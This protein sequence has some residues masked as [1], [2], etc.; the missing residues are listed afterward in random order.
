MFSQPRRINSGYNEC[1]ENL[2]T[3]F[4][5]F[6]AS[7]LAVAARGCVT[8]VNTG[9]LTQ[10]KYFLLKFGLGT[11]PCALYHQPPLC[12]ST[13]EPPQLILTLWGTWLKAAFYYAEHTTNKSSIEE[14]QTKFKYV[15]VDRSLKTIHSNY[16]GFTSSLAESLQ[17]VDEINS[18]LQA[19]GD[20]INESD[21]NNFENILKKYTVFTKLYI[22][23]IETY[24]MLQSFYESSPVRD[25]TVTR[26]RRQA[27]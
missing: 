10:N 15:S 1:S 24:L 4:A 5:I 26:L 17:I 7:V 9:K 27:N 25:C 12:P 16:K 14:S 20:T 21:K 22:S 6:T 2:L 18:L 8:W 23:T 19:I 13:P 3:V 11:C